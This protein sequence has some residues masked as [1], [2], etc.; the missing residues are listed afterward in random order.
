M[1]VSNPGPVGKIVTFYSYKG[2]TGRSMALA[3]VAWVLAS[4]GKRVLAIDWDLE[5]PGL[6]RYLEPFLADKSLERSTGIIDFVRDFATAAVA[7]GKASS[8]DWYEDYSNI[9]AHAISVNWDFPGGGLL[10]LVPAGKQDAAYAV[11]VNSFD[12]QDFYER[13]GGGILLEAVKQKLRGVYDF[14]L[15]DS[16]TGVSDTSGV[17]TIQM[18]DELVVCFTLNRQSIYGASS[19]ARSAFKQRHTTSGEPTLKIWPVP[20]RVEAFEKDRLEFASNV[21][22]ARFSGLLNQLSPEQEEEY[23]GEIAVGYEPY[24]AYDEVLAAFRDRP[25]QTTSMLARM[26]TIAK[27]LNDKPLGRM[28]TID[29]IRKAEGL[30]A[31]TTR[32]A[33][34]Y[35]PELAWLGDEYESIRKRMKGG[36]ARTEMMNLLV[37]RAQVLAS[38]RDAGAVAEKV[39]SRGTDGS[40][41]VGLAL[42]RIDTRRQHIELA[43][44]GIT[45]SRSPFE[46]YHAL[47]LAESLLPSLHPTTMPLLQA[48][49]GSQLEK[50]I[51]KDDPSRWIVAQR[52]IK[53]LGSTSGPDIP[54]KSAA[55][56]YLLAGETQVMVEIVPSTTYVRYDDPIETHGPWVK[57][58]ATHSIRL[59]RGVRIG[60]FP[61]TN[62]LYLKFIEGGGYHDDRFW[63]VGANVRE[64]FV[65]LDGA[66]TGPATW[67]NSKTL[68][69]GKEHHPVTSLSCLEAQAFVSWCNS[70]CEAPGWTWSLPLE[71]DWEFAARS[72]QGFIYPWGDAFDPTKCNTSESGIDDT[73]DV[74]RFESGASQ[75]GCYDMAG[76]VWEFVLQAESGDGSGVLRGGSFKNDRFVVRSYLRLF[77]VP[78]THRPADFGF[79]LAQIQAPNMYEKSSAALKEV[80]QK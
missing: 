51:R 34:D 4:G 5:A 12:W 9:L 53:K 20:T 75:I 47:L 62:S 35:E 79:R 10:H 21:A 45:T 31:F 16:R 14:I 63:H 43:L 33:F 55:F 73:T 36:D 25:R 11:R 3:N 71:D 26:E 78:P 27:Y 77:G 32:S 17:C 52:L 19:A 72:E 61:V 64:R 29:E 15:I 7:A 69:K 23:W 13:L 70:V 50:T 1:D 56:E 8:P 65:T 42:A 18:P 40:R 54:A 68:P 57:T 44:S 59:S 39:F 74:A 80:R 48:A 28:E 60:K 37:G 41:V 49:I 22:R 76:N 58:R 38:Q 66:S 6:H 30:A 67:L 2:G 46:Q 24:Y